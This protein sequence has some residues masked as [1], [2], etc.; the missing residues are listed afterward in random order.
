M[1]KSLYLHSIET[2][3]L[4]HYLKPVIRNI[5]CI[6][7]V[8]LIHHLLPHRVRLVPVASDPFWIAVGTV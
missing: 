5:L 3:Y 4:R 1:V 8:E 2:P 6:P 7:F